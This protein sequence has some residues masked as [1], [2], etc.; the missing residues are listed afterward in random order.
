MWL[1][2]RETAECNLNLQTPHCV[3]SLKA[4]ETYI[5]W[6]TKKFQS[7]CK[8]LCQYTIF[9]IEISL[10]ECRLTLS[11]L[12]Y[13]L[14][15]WNQFEVDFLILYLS[16]SHI[17]LIKR[18]PT[19]PVE[20]QRFCPRVDLSYFDKRLMNRWHR[21]V[22]A[23]LGSTGLYNFKWVG[24]LLVEHSHLLEMFTVI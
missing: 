24:I 16:I 11:C 6:F 4:F 1:I 20:S 5:A 7:Q 14:S 21:P 2:Y 10:L 19:V 12:S 17:T 8:I 13:P 18:A 23:Y 15:Y 9:N 3:I 22:L